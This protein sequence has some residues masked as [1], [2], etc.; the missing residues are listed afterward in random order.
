MDEKNWVGKLHD[1]VD[2]EG[3]KEVTILISNLL[4]HKDKEFE[5]MIDELY[6]NIGSNL[7]NNGFFEYIKDKKVAK[8]FLETIKFHIEKLKSKIKSGTQK[9]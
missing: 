4:K 3:Y 9:P 5:K 6:G 8:G 1:Y 2:E 7:E